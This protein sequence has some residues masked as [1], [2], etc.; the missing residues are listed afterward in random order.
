MSHEKRSINLPTCRATPTEAAW[1]RT[2]IKKDAFTGPS[3][4]FRHCLEKYQAMKKAG[5]EPELPLDFIKK[6]APK[7]KESK[8]RQPKK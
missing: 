1:F 6:P 3:H 2:E 5:Q 7:P 8:R 4:F